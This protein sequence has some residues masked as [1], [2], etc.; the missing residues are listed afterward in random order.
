MAQKTLL[1]LTTQAPERACIKID[2]HLYEL[3]S[4]E[5]LGLKEDTE[6]TGMMADFEGASAAKDWR[7]MAAILDRM[8]MGIVI[9][10]PAEILAQLND[11]KK[12]KIVQAFTKEVGQVRNPISVP[13]AA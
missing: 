8:V 12:L 2:E 1:E 11:T 10:L 13:V 5:D 7:A 4:R 3:R 6:F 9:G